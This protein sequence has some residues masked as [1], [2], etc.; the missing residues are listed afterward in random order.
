MAN[1]LLDNWYFILFV[2]FGTA[3]TALVV[4]LTSND[5]ERWLDYKPN[6][7]KDAVIIWIKR[8]M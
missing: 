6:F 8:K 1:C 7:K 2:I 5:V 4:L 3:R